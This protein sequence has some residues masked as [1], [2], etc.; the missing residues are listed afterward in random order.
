LDDVYKEWFDTKSVSVKV[1]LAGADEFLS[2]DEII[3]LTG[4]PGGSEITVTQDETKT[5]IEFRIKNDMFASDMVR[6]LV[7][8]QSGKFTYVLVNDALELKPEFS[9]RGIGT[10]CVIKEIFAAGDYLKDLV[11]SIEVQAYGNY[12]S[13]QWRVNPLR[14]YYVWA[15]MGFDADISAVVK[16][17]L[18]QPF[19]SFSKISEL[20]ATDEGREE[21]ARKG[22][23]AHLAFRLCE[24]S[25]SWKILERYM[26]EKRI[27][28]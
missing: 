20:M 3:N 12:E 5:F 2:D 16:S 26:T 23:T 7:N 9:N 18:S 24:A 27:E 15:T 17:R 25:T 10:R 8:I 19:Q 13:A 6:R 4:A 14:G 11:E 1:E 21:W 28:L 22:E